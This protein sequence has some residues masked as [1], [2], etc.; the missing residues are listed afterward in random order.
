MSY[1]IN[2]FQ[3]LMRKWD[4]LHPY[5]ALAI[6]HVTGLPG[7]DSLR[8]AAEALFAE[9]GVARLSLDGDRACYEPGQGRALVEKIG[10]LARDDSAV[11]AQIATEQLNRRFMPDGFL[12]VRFFVAPTESGHFVGRVYQHWIGD[13]YWL[14]ELFYAALARCLET[15]PPGP[16]VVAGLAPP[17]FRDAFAGYFGVD[18]VLRHGAGVA[19]EL[20]RFRLCDGPSGPARDDLTDRVTFPAVPDDALERAKRRA[21]RSGV[22]IND[23]AVA[24]LAWTLHRMTRDR[25][26]GGRRRD[27]A[28]TSMINLRPLVPSRLPRETGLYLSHFNCFLRPDREGG[29]DGTLA[30]VAAQCRGAKRTRSYLRGLLEIALADR[31]WPMIP[32]AERARYFSNQKPVA[33]GITNVRVEEGWTRGE[34]GQRVVNVGRAA[35]TGPMT[36][37]ALSVSTAAGV[38]KLGLTARSSLWSPE[39]AEEIGREFA[40]RL[41]SE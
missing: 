38:L 4:E 27:L 7:A 9:R 11:L 28:I 10:P 36:P 39:Q 14:N 24:S 19:R 12:P 18:G 37:L 25:L 16:P 2:A 35:S 15:S 40:A 33:A 23:L 30:S 32:R 21:N 17:R 22:T 26:K 5:N 13:E 31:I 41:T 8:R 34:L 1:R 20:L 29:F 3:R 6:A